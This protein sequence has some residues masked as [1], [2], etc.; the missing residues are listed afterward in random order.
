V[1][2]LD[3]FTVEVAAQAL[4]QRSIRLVVSPRALLQAFVGEGVLVDGNIELK[5]GPLRR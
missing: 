4:R 3:W 1:P 2:G 5:A